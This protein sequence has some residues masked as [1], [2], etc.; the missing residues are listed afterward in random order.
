MTRRGSAVALEELGLETKLKVVSRVE[1]GMA[2]LEA[3]DGP[4]GCEAVADSVPDVVVLDLR[5]WGKNALIF[6]FGETTGDI[7]SCR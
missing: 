7:G 6:W 2:Y 3:D 1:E 5:M 4:D